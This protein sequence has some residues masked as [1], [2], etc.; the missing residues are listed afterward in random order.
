M[1]EDLPVDFGDLCELAAFLERQ[2]AEA[3]PDSEA[4]VEELRARLARVH[5]MLDELGKPADPAAAAHAREGSE[6]AA[7]DLRSRTH[8]ET[9]PPAP[10]PQAAESDGRPDGV[11]ASLEPVLAGDPSDDE[12]RRRYIK[13]AESLGEHIHAAEVLHSALENV[14]NPGV[15]ER[16]GF[17][18]AM[19]YLGE[20]ELPR[21]RSAFLE[22]VRVNA[23]GPA[24]VSAAR[25]LLDLQVGQTD[26]E[27]VGPALELL[28]RVDNPPPAPA[29]PP[30]SIEP[31]PAIMPAPVVLAA[32]P[33]P[34]DPPPVV[35]AVPAVPADAPAPAHARHED[36]LRT[37]QALGRDGQRAEAL[38]LCRELFVEADLEAGV[39]E[40]IAEIA[41]DEDDPALY[42]HALE[43]LAQV[44]HAETKT[45]ALERLGDFQFEHLGDRRAAAASW[46]PAAQMCDGTPAEKEH[47]QL[48]YERV[49]EALPD[50]R[51]AAEH[52]AELYAQSSDWRKLP[53]VVRVLMRTDPERG[54]TTIAALERSAIEAGEVDA[55][56]SLVDEVVGLLPEASSA[57]A[58]ELRRARA[59]VLGSDSTRQ[60]D[61]SRAYRENIESSGGEDDVRSFEAFI[62]SRSSAQE[63]H[64][65][66]R[67]LYEWRVTHGPRPE[68]VLFEWAKAE[69]EIG[70]AGAAIAVYERLSK[71]APGRR[72]ALEAMCRLKL[73][74]SDFAGGLA[75]LRVLRDGGTKTEQRTLTLRM[76]RLLLEDLGQPAEAAL[77]L[78]PLLDVVP[79]VKEAHDMMVRTLSDPATSAQVAERLEE[80]AGGEDGVVARRIFRFLIQARDGTG[81]QPEARSRWFQR[82][83]ELSLPDREAALAVVLQGVKELPEAMPLWDHAE[84]L[85][86][87]LD[88][89][90]TI[91]AAYRH[92]LADETLEA[93]RADALARRM[94]AVA[95]QHDRPDAAAILEALQKVLDR[96]PGNRWALDRVKLALGAQARWDELFGLYDRAIAIAAGGPDQLE[97]LDEAACAAKDLA[98]LPARAIPYLEAIHRARPDDVSASTSLERLYARQGQTRPL[99]ALLEELRAGSTGFK[100]FEIDQRIASLH[101]DM[102]E[103]EPGLRVVERSLAEGAA[104]GDVIGLLERIASGRA[105]DA[106]S[107]AGDGRDAIAAAQMRAVAL[108]RKH[109]EGAGDAENVVRM[110]V[111]QLELADRPEL[112][113]RCMRDLVD[114]RLA[115]AKRSGQPFE[116]AT[117]QVEADVAGDPALARTAFEALLRRALRAWRDAADDADARQG[118]WHAIQSL[119]A[120]L[121]EGNPRRT[122]GLLY[123]SSRLPFESRRKRELLRDAALVCA[124]GLGDQERGIRLFAE[125]FAEDA[126]DDV[127]SSSVTAYA[128]LLD[129]T[130]QHGKLAT[131][132]EDQS[133]IQGEAGNDSEQRACLERAAGLWEGQGAIEKAIDDYRLAAALAS[134]SAHEALARI[135]EGRGEWTEAAV[136][137]EWLYA[138]A[139]A[140]ERGLRVLRLAAAYGALDDRDRARDRLERAIHD[141]VE[142]DRADQVS[143]TLIA[144]YRQDSAWR[145]LAG[146]LSADAERVADP[147]R[148]LA[149]LREAAKL[150]RGELHAPAEAAAVLERALALAPRDGSVRATLAELLEEL[151]RWDRLVEVLRDPIALERGESTRERAF[152]HHRLARALALAGRHDDS[153]AE[154]RLAAELLPTHA[155]ILHHLARAA[156]EADLLDLA[157]STNRALLL[158]LHHPTEDLGPAPPRRADAFLDL[159]EIAVRRDDS[160][161]AADLVDSAVDAALDAGD[162]PGRLEPTL[163]ERGRYSLLARAVERRL[164]RAATTGARAVALGDL[165]AVWSTHLE[166][167]PDVRVRI[168]RHAE[169][170]RRE[171]EPEASADVTTCTA[172]AAVLGS[173]GDESGKAAVNRRL[174]SLLK[175]AVAKT[176]R[177]PE[178]AKLRV[179]LAKV[180]LED[181]AEADGA[182]ALLSSAIQEDPGHREAADVLADALERRGRLDELVTL[183]QKR[184]SV[185]D[186]DTPGFLD[187]SWHL[188]CALER[189]GRTEDA[190]RVYE[191]IVDRVPADGVA[192]GP[193]VERLEAL[194]SARAADGL[195]RRISGGQG[196]SEIARRL[197]DRREREGDPEKV[198]RAL[199][200]GLSVDPGDAALALRVVDLRRAAGDPGEAVRVLGSALAARP[201]DVKL[202][203]VRATLREEAGDADGALS[204]LEAAS[205]SDA[206]ALDA[207]VEL[208]GRIDDRTGA[209][210]AAVHMVRLVDLLIGAKRS[211]DARRHV[212]RLLARTPNYAGAL[213]RLATL[214]AASNDW[215]VAID[216]YQK[217]LAIAEKNDVASLPRILSAMAEATERAGRPD[218]AREPL[219]RALSL[220]PHDVELLKSMAR[221]Y[222]LT[223]QW[224]RLVS[225]LLSQ[226]EREEKPA[227]RAQ[228]LVRAGT[229][230]L[231]KIGTVPEALRI[232]EMAR[233]ADGE[234]LEAT[235]LWAQTKRAEGRAPEALAALKEAS[236]RCRGKRSPLTARIALETAK[237]HLAVDELV[238]ALDH[239]KTAFT[240]ESRNTEIGLL[241]G[242]VAVDLDDERTAERALLA[243]T[244]APVR[245]AADRQAHATAFFHLASMAHAKNDDT[246]ARRLAGKAIAA[247]PDHPAASTLLEALG[248]SA[249]VAPAGRSVAPANASV[250]PRS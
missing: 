176:K 250:A 71:A 149:L 223:G 31:A 195:E 135:H 89:R 43:F 79:S 77:A 82:L 55:F 20:G 248:P 245:D 57:R 163:A 222:D 230:V 26:P 99:V 28:A 171:L 76:A 224:P 178:R 88:Q 155:A 233:G 98:G 232:A 190:L 1:T 111:K 104:V 44:G 159:C 63:R 38:Q 236:E 221:V 181:A 22:V 114:V 140:R 130:G 166:R 188:G 7:F 132:W 185:L 193:L 14:T 180:L 37:A 53:D 161:R 242:L 109:Y 24:A 165:V 13:A 34:V 128:A 147:E 148:K 117:G 131:L 62:E 164:E 228:L 204:D 203:M 167:S 162:E 241:L 153:L 134:E 118:A 19:L 92:A 87:E 52:L 158:A 214:S 172:L 105:G 143:E 138:Q 73:Q 136:A 207:L 96:H 116:R 80:L 70:D 95:E 101:L 239:L 5:G 212:D 169:G 154:L 54:A 47:A 187:A 175:A 30:P 170:I 194:G 182:I 107:P 2:I 168:T 227:T 146:R 108:L 42:R 59:R 144:L 61:A 32:P 81:K 16:V 200:L 237:A 102:G 184:V 72:D 198:R 209:P 120:L 75:A 33:V 202:L 196:T 208:H 12:L 90:E 6:A 25:R 234:S 142:A 49:L 246:R 36:V 27:V 173:I 219:E 231:D 11:L 225:L 125:L 177:G 100:R 78:M 179:T 67:W 215:E 51:D 66:R 145:P 210:V 46:R 213:E 129:A 206:G 238:E 113:S 133:R 60:E 85:C 48:L 226:A 39:V 86:R 235:L 186:A 199:E 23:G 150:L 8:P 122:V 83:V 243:V 174:V 50:D 216:A 18:V 160:L 244:G 124:K 151:E 115:A 29:P 93:K 74:A 152:S 9:P 103:V 229:L 157:E 97:L 137:L 217:L 141:G 15:R 65:E 220:L 218:D 112:R 127:A 91:L 249:G 139:P 211:A 84:R 110:S 201:G 40:R 58:R 189:T 94:V 126:A 191:S 240:A 45:R 3:N 4:D 123:R 197:I 56:V 68:D 69:E 41:H 10:A 205:E 35:A 17:D 156:L 21:A 121:S 192:L 183:F 64:H 106:G 119:K 247:Q